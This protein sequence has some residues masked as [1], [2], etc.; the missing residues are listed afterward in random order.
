MNITYDTALLRAL[1]Y[2]VFWV[3]FFSPYS[4]IA[5]DYQRYGL[6]DKCIFGYELGDLTQDNI[7]VRPIGEKCYNLCENEC[8]AY[9]RTSGYT[10]GYELNGDVIAACRKDCRKGKIFTPGSI[11][12]ASNAGVITTAP[13]GATVT[14]CATTSDD[15]NSAAYNAFETTL[16]VTAAS[17][18]TFNVRSLSGKM[19]GSIYMCGNETVTLTPIFEGLTNASWAASTTWRTMNTSR[20]TW[21]ARNPLATDT[22]IDVKDGD[23]LEINYRTSLR[24]SEASTT[25][26]ARMLIHRG[27]GT[28]SG[29]A[30][31]FSVPQVLPG[32]QLLFPTRAFES[33]S[34]TTSNCRTTRPDTLEI[35]KNNI[36]I[37]WNG[38]TAR[39][40][41][42]YANSCD[43]IGEKTVSFAGTLNGWSGRFSR[44]GI[45]HFDTGAASAWSDNVGGAEVSITRYGCPFYNGDR[46]QYAISTKVA[47]NYPKPQEADWID[48]TASQ[49]ENIEEL[50]MSKSGKI[51]LRIKPLPLE[52]SKLPSCNIFDPDCIASINHVKSLY[53]LENSDGAYLV[54][55]TLVDNGGNRLFSPIRE[56]IT[57]IRTYLYGTDT[58]VGTVQYLFTRFVTDTKLMGTLRAL[59]VLYIAYTGLSYALGIA[60]ITQKDGLK[61]IFA[62]S[63]VITLL[64]PNS[65]AFFHTY[66]FRLFIDGGVELMASMVNYQEYNISETTRNEILSSPDR[67]F[68]IFDA[69]LKI[70]FSKTTWI[71]VS[72]LIFSTYLGVF[73][74]LAI[75]FSGVMYAITIFK[76][77]LIYSVSIIIMGFLLLLAPIFISFSLF[78]YTRKMFMAWIK[79]L[80]TVTLQPVFIIA[81]IGMF[82]TLLILGLKIVLGFSVCEACWVRFYLPGIIDKCIVHMFQTIQSLH[83]PDDVSISS[84]IVAYGAIFYLLIISQA[85]YVFI[86]YMVQLTNQLV[87]FGFYGGVNMGAYGNI[88]D[89][90]KSVSMVTGGASYALGT[91]SEVKARQKLFD[92]Y[93]S[94]PV[95]DIVKKGTDAYDDKTTGKK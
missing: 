15:Q 26:E 55:A 10:S 38:L 56:V 39:T 37:A 35:Q 58:S 40:S 11:K 68:E 89:Y 59:L 48:I 23:F 61:R 82:A 21:S 31:A 77:I 60:Q 64:A 19:R 45:T 54:T 50:S 51:F 80:I 18:V 47:G 78:E 44:L 29:F 62:I 67:V 6:Y 93:T 28:Q 22:G 2:L 9:S 74:F 85:M 79:Q 73:L 52:N 65:W 53:S 90:G 57:D 13:I 75:L 32:D 8:T 5:E 12:V 86:P 27:A 3:A 92:S 66:L 91:S 63:M 95:K 4:A 41:T 94:K 71:K 69:P 36:E 70:I 24:P 46:L 49:L 76:A 34:S 87:G 14:K 84:P 88:K 7:F 17:K 81:A 16:V 83:L 42:E 30:S 72:A 25:Q 43:I 20:S 1:K 33:G